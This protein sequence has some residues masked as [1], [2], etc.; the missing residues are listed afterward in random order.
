MVVSCSECNR[1]YKNKNSLKSHRNN[2]HKSDRFENYPKKMIDANIEES[3]DPN[4]D[5]E[6]TT[7]EEVSDQNTSSNESNISQDSKEHYQM[8]KVAKRKSQRAENISDNSSDSDES[9]IVKK[10]N[11]LK[12]RRRDDESSDESLYG[13]KRH[14]GSRRSGD[15][16]QHTKLIKTI[17]KC[18]LD[19]RIPLE[20]PH[21]VKLK[22][23][24]NF[25]RYVAHDNL[26]LA[27]KHIQTGGSIFQTVLKTVLPILSELL[28]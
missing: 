2:Y 22:P 18:I 13:R 12:K 21:I 17:C 24:R 23:H 19:G 6:E 7:N 20:P 28:L 9:I 1:S 10:T 14:K 4:T 25:I 16:K 3:S 11:E 15:L 27:K 26:N 5:V 8:L